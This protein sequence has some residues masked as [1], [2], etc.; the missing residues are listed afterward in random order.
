LDALFSFDDMVVGKWQP[1]GVR[2]YEVC[3]SGEKNQSGN[4]WW[5]TMIFVIEG[6]GKTMPK[7]I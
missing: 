6:N 3:L 4:N 5:S 7:K 2:Y 1:E